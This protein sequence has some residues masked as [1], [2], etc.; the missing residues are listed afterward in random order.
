MF[1]YVPLP[2]PAHTVHGKSSVIGAGRCLRTKLISDAP[3][4]DLV[5]Q[6]RIKSKTIVPWLGLETVF[7]GDTSLRGK[8][9]DLPSSHLENTREEVV[10]KMEPTQDTSSD[11]SPG[12]SCIWSS[13][14]YWTIQLYEP[15][16]SFL[17]AEL[18]VTWSSKDHIYGQVIMFESTRTM[19]NTPYYPPTMLL[20]S[21]SEVYKKGHKTS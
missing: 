17:W 4:K 13:V 6:V 18:S 7:P 2:D 20:V 15:I 14:Y 1:R 12:S 5:C 19:Q 21:L 11:M 10:W 3:K 9:Q 16:N 8:V